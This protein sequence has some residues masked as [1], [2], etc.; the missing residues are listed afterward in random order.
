VQHYAVFAFPDFGHVNPMLEVTRHLVERGHRVT[1]VLDSKYQDLVEGTGAA[2]VGYQPS[3][4]RLGSGH[5]VDAEQMGE[6]GLDVL[7][8]ATETILPRAREAFADD[9]PDV[10]LY[11][12]ESFVVARTISRMWGRPTIQFFPYFASNETYSLHA[13][14]FDPP[15]PAV[16][17]GVD[18]LLEAL[19]RIEPDNSDVWA[20]M[21]P[22]TS[23]T[24]SSCLA[25]FSRPATASTSG[26]RSSAIACPTPPSARSGRDPTAMSRSCSFHWARSRTS[27]PGSSGPAQ[28]RSRTRPGT[29][30]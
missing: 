2:I 17:R 28:R 20:L 15:S 26:S 1:Y 13:E 30:S 14:V 11:D 22:T 7:A 29:S 9:V 18:A 6:L 4:R 21:G 5:S 12:F 27:G 3:R 19:A 10:V 25:S 23:A 24:S 16:L 8:D